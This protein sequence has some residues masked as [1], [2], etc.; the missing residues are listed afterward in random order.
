MSECEKYQE[1]ISLMIDGELSE[2]ESTALAEHLKVCPECSAV[3]AAF[4][5]LSSELSSKLAEPPVGLHEN[6]MAQIRRDNIKKKNSRLSKP[7]K[8]I[9]A[10]AACLALLT[11]VSAGIKPLR[12]G[13]AMDNAAAPAAAA[14]EAVAEDA[15]PRAAQYDTAPAEPADEWA[16]GAEDLPEEAADPAAFEGENAGSGSLVNA[17]QPFLSGAVGEL[18][19]ESLLAFLGGTACKIEE[20]LSDGLYCTLAL[21]GEDGQQLMIYVFDGALY[22]NFAGEDALYASARSPEELESFI[23]SQMRR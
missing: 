23:A 17:P 8:N 15:G 18:E 1:H 16:D 13:S 11:G 5:A 21:S 6:V 14:P 20:E 19:R 22:Y 10:A 12:M 3:Y 2:S 7:I 9:L 4:S